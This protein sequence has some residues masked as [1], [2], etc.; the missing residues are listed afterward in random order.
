MS[1]GPALASGRR[2]RPRN[3]ILAAGSLLLAFLLAEVAARWLLAR[4]PAPYPSTRFSD[5][6]LVVSNSL[7]YRDF[8]HPREKPPGVFRVAAVGDSFTQAAGVN[9]DDAWSRRLERY[10]NEFSG[11]AEK[12]YQVLNFGMPGSSTPRQVNAIRTQVASFQPDLIILGYCLNDA[13][14]E[15]RH[16]STEINPRKVYGE[17]WARGSGLGAWLYD[18]VALYRLARE[19]L[20]NTK[21]NRMQRA[22]YREIY[23]EDYP[24]WRKSR[25]A[26]A[27]LGAFRRDS[28]IPVAAMIFPLFSWPFDERYP[29]RGTHDRLRREFEAVGIPVLDL[30]PVYR[31]LDHKVLEAVPFR[32]PHPSDV[33][34]RL[35]AEELY[36][37]LGD[38]VLP[39]GKVHA[40]RTGLRGLRAP[41]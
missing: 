27:Q 1:A 19:R 25:A 9:F 26:I 4:P 14:D 29:F 8:E 37:W 36:T 22:Y 2:E 7:G 31:G 40:G 12:R 38:E 21:I 11:D 16:R 33:A 24:G 30:L 10:F 39:V 15:G 23:R 5:R 17:R 3:L 41:Y 34:H 32:D 18:R 35:A 6:A 13:E 20:R 28:G